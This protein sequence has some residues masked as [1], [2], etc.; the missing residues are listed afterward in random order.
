MADIVKSSAHKSKMELQME[1]ATVDNKIGRHCTTIADLQE[2]RKE[3]IEIKR[4]KCSKEDAELREISQKLEGT[5]DLMIEAIGGRK[6]VIGLLKKLGVL[7]G[8]TKLDRLLKDETSGS[9]LGTVMHRVE[10]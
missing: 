4:A 7:P 6:M 3:L 9:I 1:L 10:G 8:E 2:R 5:K